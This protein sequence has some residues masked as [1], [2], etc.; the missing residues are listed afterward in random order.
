MNN[1]F[2][3]KRVASLVVALVIVAV[4]YAQEVTST[5]QQFSQEDLERAKNYASRGIGFYTGRNGATKDYQKAY[6]CL[7][8]AAKY[9]NGDA[10][11]VL[12][13]MYENGNGVTKDY[14]KALEWY[15]KAAEQN[16][17][18]A[19]NNVGVFYDEGIGVAKDPVEAAKWY[20]KAA[21]NN[22]ASAQYNLAQMYAEGIGVEK[23][24]NEAL[25]WYK[26]SLSNGVKEAQ[27]EISKLQVEKQRLDAEKAR[28]ERETA[29][30]VGHDT[31]LIVDDDGVE[32]VDI[33]DY[34]VIT[35]EPEPEEEEVFLVVETQPEFPGGMAALLEFLRT[36]IKYPTICRENNIQGRVLV[37]FVVNKDGSISDLEVVKS[38]NPALDKEALRVMSKMPNWK[39][40]TQRGKTVRVKYTVPVN[41]RLN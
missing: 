28:R 11:T 3:L 2:N 7:I 32:W 35:V 10:L 13:H 22:Y 31:I 25:D 9:N 41:F 12:G 18:V 15:K 37:S 33:A 27:K 39:P 6:D 23:D 21:E 14:T 24:I 17:A 20:K 26:K 8:E 19:Q 29:R 30:V 36:N 16:V 34:D 40:A 5:E 38:V 4:T 1:G